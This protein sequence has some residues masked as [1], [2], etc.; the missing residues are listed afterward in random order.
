MGSKVNK[1]IANSRNQKTGDEVQGSERSGDPCVN[2][3]SVT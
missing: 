1:V 2:I 3:A